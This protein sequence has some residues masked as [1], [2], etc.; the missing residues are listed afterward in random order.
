VTADFVAGQITLTE[1]I[2]S[3]VAWTC[4]ATTTTG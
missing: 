2:T 1:N 4:P 3:Y